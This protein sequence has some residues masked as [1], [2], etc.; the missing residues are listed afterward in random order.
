MG[1]T[2]GGGDVYQLGII[3]GGGG[4]QGGVS[5]EGKER[6][7][8]RNRWL[9]ALYIIPRTLGRVLDNQQHHSQILPKLLFD[10]LRQTHSKLCAPS[11]TSGRSHP[12]PVF[13]LT[14][15]TGHFC[16]G[17]GIAI[18]RTFKELKR[19]PLS[20]QSISRL[21]GN[22]GVSGCQTAK[23][24]EVCIQNHDALLQINVTLATLRYLEI[25]RCSHIDWCLFSNLD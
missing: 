23:W 13:L 25:I 14:L 16:C 18:P 7:E 17:Q 6:K 15:V 12:F 10:K 11:W 20:L 3:T 1:I 19:R 9:E 24:H 4:G 8:T 21:W 5:G 2:T 22:G